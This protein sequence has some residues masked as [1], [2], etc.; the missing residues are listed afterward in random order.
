MTDTEPLSTYDAPIVIDRDGI[1]VGG[2]RI[3]G[4]IT[5]GGVVVHKSRSVTD[6]WTVTVQLMTGRE[7]I[8]GDGAIRA[9]DGTIWSDVNPPHETTT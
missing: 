5:A 6:H 1:T 7:P 9:A 8:L 4:I 3:P 2:E